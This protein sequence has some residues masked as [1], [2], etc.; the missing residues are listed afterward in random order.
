[1]LKTL[2]PAAILMATL[3]ACSTPMQKPVKAD[4][5]KATAAQ[6]APKASNESVKIEASK[7]VAYACGPS[8]KEKLRVTYG[9]SKNEVVVA[10]VLFREKA[11]PILFRV[12]SQ[13][14]SNTFANQGITWSAEKA[15][16]ANLDKV[17]GNMLTQEAVEVVNGKKT[18]VSQIVTKY[19]KLDK[20]ATAKLAK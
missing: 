13:T 16:A 9:I 11:S 7:E 2:V 14:D 1:M 20:A 17:D 12:N 18:Q 10:Q 4:A 8:G 15:D 19:C 6:T 3:T 5:A